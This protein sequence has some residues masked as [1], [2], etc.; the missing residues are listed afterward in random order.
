MQIVLFGAPPLQ[1][2]HGRE[3]W[4]KHTGRAWHCWFRAIAATIYLVYE[5]RGHGVAGPQQ[6]S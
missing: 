5:G 6:A 2:P 1:L 4:A 3:G